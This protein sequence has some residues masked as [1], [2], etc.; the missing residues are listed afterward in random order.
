MALAE[1]L[2]QLSQLLQDPEHNAEKIYA[3][4]SANDNLAEFE[5]A[6]FFVHDRMT[7]DLTARVRHLDPT[8]RRD[9]AAFI[10]RLCPRSVAAK[11]LRPLVKDADIAT[12]KRARSVV[13][14]LQLGDVALPD[15]RFD[16]G[17]AYTIY[18]TTPGAYNPSGWAFG[19]YARKQRGQL[20]ASALARH[21]LPRLEDRDDVAIFLDCEDDGALSALLRPGTAPGSAYV[22]FEVAKATGGTRRIAAPRARLRAAQRKIL[23]AILA[24]VPVHRA[25]HGFVKAR[26]T[27]TNASLHTNRALVMKLDLVDFF[28]S[29]HYRRVVGLFETI[30]YAT[31][32]AEALAGVCTYR[33][34]L[35]DGRMVWPGLLPQGAPTSPA[36]TNLV[37]RRLDARLAALAK[38]A[39]GTYTRYA[40]DMTFSFATEPQ[41]IGRLLWFIDQICAQ[42]GF[43]ENTKKR[44]IYRR[45]C[46]QRVT[47]VVVNEHVAVPREDRRRFRAILANVKKNG[48]EAEARGHEDFE[49]YLRGYAAYVNMVQPNLGARLARELAGVLS[50]DD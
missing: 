16:P 20:D 48:L 49:A 41:R 10:G 13:R 47:G 40:D 37:C 45:S 39:G 34:K 18:C 31:A 21:G 5:V 46:Q 24:K 33:P 6:R 28:P 23:S 25:A 50:D 22:E 43:T 7:K 44:R 17:R 27:V 1:V 3:L 29:I 9:A 35:P 8:V 38:K 12:R 42:E 32:A 19:I 4:L 15:K 2:V 14:A 11:L 36:I 30:G 26:S